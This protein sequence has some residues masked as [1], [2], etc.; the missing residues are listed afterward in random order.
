MPKICATVP[1]VSG[2]VASHRKPMIAANTSAVALVTGTIRK[3]AIAA[4]RER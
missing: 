3:Q 2:T 4:A 1:L